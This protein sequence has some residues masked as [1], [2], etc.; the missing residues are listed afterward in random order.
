MDHA[1]SFSEIVLVDRARGRNS[2]Y[3]FLKQ[4]LEEY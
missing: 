4:W 2:G 3:S 1:K